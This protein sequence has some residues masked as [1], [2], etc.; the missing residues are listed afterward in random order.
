M[1]EFNELI[2]NFD[3][4]RDYIRDFYIYGFKSR[5]DFTH[6]SARTYDNERRR[7]ESYMGEYMKWD[8]SKSGK[9]AFISMDCAKVPVN[10]LYAAWKSKAFTANDIMLHFY[11]LDV[12]IANKVF[13][14][15]DLTDQI[16]SLSGQTFDIQTVRNKCREYTN[17][18][19]LEVEKRGKV[20]FYKRSAETLDILTVAAPNLP[21]AIKFFQGSALF[22]EIGSFILDEN[23]IENDLFSFQ[24]NYVAHTLEDGILLDLLS[25]IRKGEAISF[26]NYSEKRKSTSTIQGIPLKIFISASTGRR[27]LCL[28]RVY[29]RRFSTYRLDHIKSVTPIGVCPEIM[30]YRKKLQKNI[31]RVWGVGFGGRSRLE[32]ICMKLYIR[33]GQEDFILD[34]IHREGKG[35]ELLRLEP[36]IYLYT[37]EVYDSSDISPWIKTFTGRIIQLEGTNDAVINRF[38]NDINRMKTIYGIE[39]STW[40]YSQKSTDVITP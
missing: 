14:L 37:K 39:E 2:R 25:S 33:E 7:I 18:G 38:Y 5:T 36:N 9:T 32:V 24:H 1:A 34:R 23:Q 35:G 16:C 11:I 27:Y 29:Q 17:M 22:G 12:L 4:I 6:K 20:F 31:D 3:K 13:S 28:Y 15:E 8:Y 10:P 30:E 26:V 21:E 19:I 40:N